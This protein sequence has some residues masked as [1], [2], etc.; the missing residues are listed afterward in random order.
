MLAIGRALMGNPTVLLMD[1]PTEGLAPIIV[2]HLMAAIETLS[3]EEGI[4]LLL[5]EQNARL[6]LD[7]AP[8]TVVIDGGRVAYD[9][10]S[11]DLR[12]DEARLGRL[13]GVESG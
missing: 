7:F 1:E 3:A 6:A 8:R 11:A 13:V 10:A 4:T 5:V 12:A 9:G 2:E